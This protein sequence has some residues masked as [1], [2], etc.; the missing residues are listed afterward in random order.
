MELPTSGAAMP[1]AS[2]RR[3][4][5]SEVIAVVQPNSSL[6]SLKMVPKP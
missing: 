4:N 5:A 3:E 2:C 1:P 6:T